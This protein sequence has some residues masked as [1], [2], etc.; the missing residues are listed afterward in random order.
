VAAAGYAGYQVGSAIYPHIALPLGDTI[1]KVCGR[2]PDFCYNRWETERGRC[3]QWKN[4]GMRWVKACQERARY[5]MQLCVANGG[6]PN[7]LE[8]PEWSPFR[9]YPR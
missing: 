2:D 7:P 3:W 9:D 4:L 5:R 6:K 8:P 1:D